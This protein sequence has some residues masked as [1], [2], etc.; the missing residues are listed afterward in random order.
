MDSLKTAT[1][2]TGNTIVPV[3]PRMGASETQSG[4]TFT[5]TQTPVQI[6]LTPQQAMALCQPDPKTRIPEG[7]AQSKS[8]IS[9]NDKLK[10]AVPGPIKMVI[11]GFEIP[12]TNAK[13]KPRF[14]NGGVKGGP[15]GVEF[16]LK[17]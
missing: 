3:R 7:P 11:E 10:D 4:D 5:P 12:G 16:K 15:T 6:F 2:P 13:I 1:L 17:W 8:E 9:T 14:D